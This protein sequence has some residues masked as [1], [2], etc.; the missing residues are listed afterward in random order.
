M[1]RKKNQIVPNNT[2]T[3]FL[4][5]T[6]PDGKVKVDFFLK[7]KTILLTQD[8]IA[9]LF[10]VQR[11]AVT[12]RQKTSLIPAN[13][14]KKWLFPKWNSPLNTVLLMGKPKPGWFNFTIWMPSSQ[15]VTA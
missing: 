4:L 3:E 11:P 12:K 7:D 8:R 2:F 6:K 10:G 13:C 1:G 14:G 5:Y 15:S 9:E